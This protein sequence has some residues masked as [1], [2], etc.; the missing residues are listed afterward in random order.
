M[1]AGSRIKESDGWTRVYI[2]PISTTHRHRLDLTD[3]V[4]TTVGTIASSNLRSSIPAELLSKLSLFFRLFLP[5]GKLHLSSKSH[6]TNLNH[7]R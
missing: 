4:S 5:V 2:S 1:S 7:H 3:S 6:P